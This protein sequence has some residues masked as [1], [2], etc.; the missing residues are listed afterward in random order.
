MLKTVIFLG[1]GA[2][3]SDG[4]PLQLELF[5]YYFEAFNDVRIHNKY[6]GSS[7]FLKKDRLVREFLT[8]FFGVE[9]FEMTNHNEFPTFE[10]AL[11]I[12]DLSIIKAEEYR[13]KIGMLNEY[14][15]ALI[16]SMGLAIE[17]G[18]DYKNQMTAFENNHLKLVNAIKDSLIP[19][20]R[21]K[22]SFISTNYDLLIDNAI[23]NSNIVDG[24]N[25]M[26]IFKIHGSLNLLYC[27]V[28]KKMTTYHGEKIAIT[29][30]TLRESVNC[31]RCDSLQKTV[32]VPPTYFKELSN[33]YLERQWS[34]AEEL[35]TEAEHI[36]FC[37][38]S[39]P[40][41]DIHVKYL[42]KKAEINRSEQNSIKITVLNYYDEKPDYISKIEEERYKRF[43][44]KIDDEHFQYKMVSFSDFVN[45]PFEILV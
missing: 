34:Q 19:A 25:K 24:N 35:L 1:A 9:S 4:A 28:C 39:F 21:R 38:Y 45:N 15:E 27:P 40:D 29:A 43:F 17:Y 14:R 42:L 16:Y 22:M 23:F 8:D 30:M 5:R 44:K 33:H 13:N 11:G 12:L 26:R 20:E 31:R 2:S 36:V 37:G 3:K 32:I 18:L 41:A 7:E 10:E 6:S